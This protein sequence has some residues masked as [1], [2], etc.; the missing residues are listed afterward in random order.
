[1]DKVEVIQRHK[2]GNPKIENSNITWIEFLSF[3]KPETEQEMYKYATILLNGE[4]LISP[5][6]YTY[7]LNGINLRE[8]EKV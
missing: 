6:G 1:M 4:F 5:D 2:S 8:N 3:V 7:F